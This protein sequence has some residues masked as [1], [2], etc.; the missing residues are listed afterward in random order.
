M[1]VLLK[2]LAASYE[3]AGDRL[4]SLA[5]RRLTDKSKVVEHL[6]KNHEDHSTKDCKDAVEEF[7]SAHQRQ[8]QSVM[9]SFTPYHT[10]EEFIK[11]V[12]DVGGF[13]CDAT[14]DKFE[15]I[16]EKDPLPTDRATVETTIVKLM[17]EYN[18]SIPIDDK[19]KQVARHFSKDELLIQLDY[20]I[21]S[22]KLQNVMAIRENLKFNPEIDTD[23]ILERMLNMMQADGNMET[24]VT[25]LKHFIWTIK[26]HIFGRGVK[27]ELWLAIFGGQNIGKNYLV[28]NVFA[29]PLRGHTVDTE[30]SSIADIGREIGKFQNRFLINFDELAKGSGQSED[31]TDRLSSNGVAQL[32]AILTR[33]ELT[34]RQMGGQNQMVLPKNFSC[35]S[36]ANLH[37]YDVIDDPT[38]MRRFFEITLSHPDNTWFNQD[39]MKYLMDNKE[40]LYQGVDE[41]L[42]DGYLLPNTEV[43]S[44]V[45]KIQSGYKAK[46]SIDFWLED[47]SY[48]VGEGEITTLSDLYDDYKITCKEGGLSAFGKIRFIAGIERRFEVTKP[49]NKKSVP[50]EIRGD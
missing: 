38:G 36:T 3:V 37:I 44:E 46:S 11:Y 34:I 47:G 40:A 42:E 29:P 35:M 9:E 39:D 49:N 14:G 25:I 15:I 6:V 13:S 41:D 28:D 32:K 4:R 20:H 19:G 16:S 2:T 24:N 22:L 8:R 50:A 12:F 23:T 1:D 5:N 18:H 30:L 26:R 27:S 10:P 33:K 17:Y 48:E 7:I 31:S 21:R 45:R 43:W